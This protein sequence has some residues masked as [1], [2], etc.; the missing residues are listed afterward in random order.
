MI[1]V[2]AREAVAGRSPNGLRVADGE[3]IHGR[4]PRRLTDRRASRKRAHAVLRSL[5]DLKRVR[6]CGAVGVGS[7]VSIRA[8]VTPGGLVAG[9]AG[10]QTCG[11]VWACPTCSAKIA[12]HRTQE[13]EDGIRRWV[14]PQWRADRPAELVAR[15]GQLLTQLAAIPLEDRKARKLHDRKLRQ[16]AASSV[17]ASAPSWARPGSFVLLTLTVRHN[18]ENSLAELWDLVGDSWRDLTKHRRYSEARTRLGVAGF[19]RTTEATIG[20]AGWHVHLHVLMFLNGTPRASDVAWE[21]SAIVDQWLQ[22]V[23]ANGGTATRDGQDWRQLTGTADALAGIAGYV[24]KGT[25]QESE[26]GARAAGAVA[27]EVGRSDL[28]R[29]RLAESRAPFQLL[30]DIVDEVEETGAVDATD[31]ALWSEWETTSRGRRQQVWSR[32]L[33]DLLGL[34]EELTDQEV[35][36]LQLD[37]VELVRIDATDWRA[38]TLDGTRESDLLDAIEDCATVEEGRRVAARLLTRYGVPFTIAGG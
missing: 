12:A 21:G 18:A 11:S 33:R 2:A 15:R 20:Q 32:G 36:E 37:G 25:Y 22:V 29:A 6:H 9:V 19:H 28:K 24:H 1:P 3:P 38:F 30:G 8:A 10:T 34:D 13:L 26:A 14:D 17:K 5:T 23:Q 35:A 27:L 7:E 16:N 4:G 31:W